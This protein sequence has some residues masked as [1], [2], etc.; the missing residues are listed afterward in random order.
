MR[1]FFIGLAVGAGAALTGQS[2][3]RVARPAAKKAIRAG[4]EGYIV[5]RR[6]LARMAEEVEDLVAEVSHEMAEAAAEADQAVVRT[7]T[8]AAEEK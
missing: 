7:S 1:G 2:Y 3:W 5:A 4:I 6:N 8:A